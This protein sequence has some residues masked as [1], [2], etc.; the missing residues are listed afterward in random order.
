[1]SKKLDR[2]VDKRLLEHGVRQG[3]Q[4]FLQCRSNALV[5]HAARQGD[6]F[7]R[8][9]VPFAFT[10]QQEKIAACKAAGRQ[11]QHVDLVQIVT[12]LP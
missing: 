9:T 10:M 12:R 6:E 4:R 8:K 7:G 1:M 3:R 11:W 5:K 2:Q